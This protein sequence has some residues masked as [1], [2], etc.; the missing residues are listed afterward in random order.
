MFLPL[1]RHLKRPLPILLSA[2]GLGIV[3]VGGFIYFSVRSPSEKSE[4]EKYTVVADVETLTVEIKANGTLQPVQSV[5]ISPKTPGRLV[6]LLVE[7]GDVVKQGQRLAVMENREAFV[8]GVQAQAQFEETVAR[9]KEAEIKIPS[10]IQQLQI[11]VVQAQTRVDQ[12]RSQLAIA[13]KRLQEVQ[14]RIPRDIDQLRAQLQAAESRLKLAENRRTRNQEL[15]TAGAISQD[16]FDEVSNDYL[17]AQAALVEILQRLQQTQN[18]ASPE[19]AQIQGQVE[20]LQAA[21]AEAKQ[22]VQGKLSALKQRENTAP[23]EL[24]ILK[25]SV[26]AAQAALERSKIQYED[27]YITAPF[28]GVVTQK[29]A[30]EGAFVTPTT[31][32]SATASATSS[33]ILALARGLEIVARVPEVDI[34]TL[35]LGQ[36]VDIRAEAFPSERFQ[37]RV[38]RIAPEAIV[39]NN[40]TSFEVMVGLVTGQEK[41]RSKMN[42]DVIFQADDVSN[43]LTVPTVAI[44]T[45][46]GK[47]GVMIPDDQEQPKFQPVTIGLVLDEN[48]QILSGIK[49][50][51]RVFTELPKGDRQKADS[52]PK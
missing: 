49:P 43:A 37:G 40:V 46:L 9:Y 10:Q 27:T 13:E 8:D 44:V 51:Q 14:A 23:A 26:K 52:Q 32:A 45:Q 34:S 39:E 28:A 33:S 4:L 16:R 29:F 41:L 19:V 35:K 42:V 48:T 11:E 21:I 24:A 17:N 31:S 1:S 2:L 50:G 18:T 30:T 6:K 12:A 38:I 36:T 47:T 20:Q 3:L 25:A 5:N 7:Q 15:I 22:I